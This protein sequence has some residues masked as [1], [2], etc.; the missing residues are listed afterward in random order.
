MNNLFLGGD[1][2]KGYADFFLMNSSGEEMRKTFKLMD[3]KEGHLK[4]NA[5][6]K[7]NLK[8]CR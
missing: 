7:A 5:I 2:N 8:Q 6:L 4:L 3:I 1:V